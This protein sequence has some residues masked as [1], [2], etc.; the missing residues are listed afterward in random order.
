M[1]ILLIILIIFL[2]LLGPVVFLWS[3][4]TL[5]EQGNISAY[6]PHNFWTYLACYGIFVTLKS[7]SVRSK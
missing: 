5:F 3:L 6:I 1:K 4:N 7:T 2:A